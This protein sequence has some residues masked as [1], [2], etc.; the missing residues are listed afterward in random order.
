VSGFVEEGG[1][2]AFERCFVVQVAG[3][4]CDSVRGGGV[5]GLEFRDGVCHA[6]GIGGGDCDVGAEFEG[7]FCDAVADAWFVLV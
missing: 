5:G 6:V 4:A 2:V 1:E 3:V 7:G